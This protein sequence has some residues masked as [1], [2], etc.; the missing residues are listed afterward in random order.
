[1]NTVF[2]NYAL[3]PHMTVEQ[4][5]MFG[6]RMTRTSQADRQ[7]RV[8]EATTLVRLDTGDQRKPFDLSG[9]QQ[10]RVALARAL[11]N[12][13]AVLLLDEPLGALDL[14]LR[15]EMQRELR[16]LNRSLETTFLYVTH[17]Q[18]EALAMSD[19]IA[20]MNHGQILQ[21]GTPE[22][23]YERPGSRFV[24]EFIG[25]TNMFTGTI[26][27]CRDGVA[28]VDVVGIGT[29]RASVSAGRS[30]A[31]GDT[32]SVAV[33]PERVEISTAHGSLASANRLT[34]V[35][36]EVIYAGGHN[37]VVIEIAGRN[38][39]TAH[40]SR[41]TAGIPAFSGGDTLDVSFSASDT[42]VL[43]D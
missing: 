9:G 32:V 35:V 22:E 12:R 7:R 19:R 29:I 13:P 43:I 2:Q 34:G 26:G 5:I 40:V 31:R 15:T 37:Q 10:Q 6:L 41:T 21:V 38:R 1:M 11:V 24:A 16:Q 39:F 42:L 25:Q 4:N 3:F 20:V 33:R 27:D 17:D 23:I 8:D 36:V 30:P 28:E 14:K 18:D